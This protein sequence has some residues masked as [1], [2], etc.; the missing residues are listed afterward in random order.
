MTSYCAMREGPDR[1]CTV[2][3]AADANDPDPEPIGFDYK[4]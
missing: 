3:A 2:S 4:S 1:R